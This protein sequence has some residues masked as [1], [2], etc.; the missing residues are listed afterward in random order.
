MKGDI[1][2]RPT[3]MSRPVKVDHLQIFPKYFGRTEPKRLSLG[4]ASEAFGNFM[5]KNGILQEKRPPVHPLSRGLGVFS[6]MG[7]KSGKD[8][9][10]HCTARLNLAEF[11]FVPLIKAT[12]NYQSYTSRADVQLPLTNLAL[13]L[14]DL[15]QGSLSIIP[16]R[17]ALQR[18][19]SMTFFTVL[20]V[21]GQGPG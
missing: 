12:D 2:V 13:I 11:F 4:F 1:S 19:D 15:M 21:I 17:A 8:W 16:E 20:W 9:K 7:W 10:V 18:K 14:F 6:K 5:S 3:Q